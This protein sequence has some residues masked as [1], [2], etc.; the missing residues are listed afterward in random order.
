MG[1]AKTTQDEF[2]PEDLAYYR[3]EATAQ[4][5]KARL[6]VIT[7]NDWLDRIDLLLSLGGSRVAD[8][9]DTPW[10]TYYKCGLSAGR[11]AEVILAVEADIKRRSEGK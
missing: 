3:Q 1:K 2:G 11:V 7:Y 5:A 6:R 10:E 4:R 8:Y 9:P